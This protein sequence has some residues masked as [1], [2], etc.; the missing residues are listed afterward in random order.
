MN[1]SSTHYEPLTSMPL[2]C[3]ARPAFLKSKFNH[4]LAAL[5]NVKELSNQ[6]LV[7]PDVQAG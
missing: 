7:F 4:L 5:A 3:I 1:A 2:R 6:L